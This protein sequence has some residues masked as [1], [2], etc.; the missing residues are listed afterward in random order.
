MET[1]NPT[2]GTETLCARFFWCFTLVHFL[3]WLVLPLLTKPN[4]PLDVVECFM[5]GQEWVLASG[6]HPPLPSWITEILSLLTHRSEIAPYLASQIFVFFAFFSIWSLARKILPGPQALLAVCSMELYSYF[7]MY[8]LEFNNS[9][10]L[11]GCWSLAVWAFYSALEKGRLRYWIATGLLLGLATLAKY[12]GFMLVVIMLAFMCYD[13][14]ARKYWKTPGPYLTTVLA[15]LVFLPHFLAVWQMGFSTLG[16]AGERM[17]GEA[18]FVTKHLVYP[19]RFLTTQLGVILPVLLFFSFF[20]RFRWQRRTLEPGEAFAARFLA[21]LVL[22]PLGLQTI[23][24]IVA[25]L[26]L[27]TIYGSHIWIFLGLF[28]AFYFRPDPRLLRPR[29]L[30]IATVA[31]MILMLSVTAFRD[32]GSPY[33]RQKPSRIHCPGQSIAVEVERVWHE[34][35]SEPCPNLAGSWWLAGNVVA[36]G[37]DHPTVFAYFQVDDFEGEHILSVWA[38]AEKINRE[39]G[40]YLWYADDYP[41]GVPPTLYEKSPRAEP[42]PPISVPYQTAA[43]LKPLQLGLAIVPPPNR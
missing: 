43:P 10:S 37:K 21:F 35:F 33:L 19:L 23:V 4:Y 1:A 40:I 24:S 38:D 20:C 8:S 36:Y 3:C 11:I 5:I 14:K 16:Y 25:G 42:L 17:G 9:I 6:K 13:G 34:R 22:F 28:L 7:T 12:S 31:A 39:G 2:N 30:A 18:S 27:S 32:I 41:G 15:L 29:N 26:K